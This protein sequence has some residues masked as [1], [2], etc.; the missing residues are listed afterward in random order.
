MLIMTYKKKAKNPAKRCIS[1]K[2][3]IQTNFNIF[4]PKKNLNKVYKLIIY[5]NHTESFL[6]IIFNQLLII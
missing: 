6:R 2:K 3:N 5:F 1:E 4:L